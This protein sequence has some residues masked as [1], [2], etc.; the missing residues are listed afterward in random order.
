MSNP[1]IN[2]IYYI[3]SFFSLQGLFSCLS[4][5]L[6]CHLLITSQSPTKPNSNFLWGWDKNPLPTELHQLPSG[7]NNLSQLWIP[8]THHHIISTW[9]HAIWFCNLSC[10]KFLGHVASTRSPV[11]STP[12]FSSSSLSYYFKHVYQKDQESF[13]PI[14][15]CCQTNTFQLQ[16]IP[17]TLIK[18]LEQ[19]TI[20]KTKKV[21]QGQLWT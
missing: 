1:W 20:V 12:S 4:F 6:E 2:C 16:D 15:T 21:I 18:R 7:L 8:V 9:L 17:K 11:P 14:N 3:G 10:F 19:W 5:H 13:E